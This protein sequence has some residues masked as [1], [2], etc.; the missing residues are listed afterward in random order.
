MTSF[1]KQSRNITSES[2][3]DFSRTWKSYEVLSS[4]INGSIFSADC[5]DR[6]ALFDDVMRTVTHPQFF[7]NCD[8]ADSL[9][10]KTP[11]STVYVIIGLSCFLSV[12]GIALANYLASLED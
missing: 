3:C 10:D 7:A 2:L 11:Q 12:S 8:K 1:S 6:Y 5:W 9:E 4:C